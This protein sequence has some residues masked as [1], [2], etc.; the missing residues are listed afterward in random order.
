MSIESASHNS[1]SVIDSINCP[2]CGYVQEQRPDCIKCGVVFSKYYALFPAGKP[3]DSAHVESQGAR[4]SSAD[5]QA[6]LSELQMQ[7]K[8]LSGRFAEIEFEKVERNKLRQ[9]LKNLER[10]LSEN[11]ES[12]GNR[13]EQPPA[14]EAPHET[15]DPR[16]PEIRERLE[17]AESKLGSVDFAG[18][19][20]VE[21]SEK[22]EA[23][24]REIAELSEKN[25]SN[26][27]EIDDLKQQ[28]S[29]LRE[30][31]NRIS[32]QLDAIAQTQKTE[33]P[34]TPL[35]EDVHIIRKNLDELRAFLHKPNES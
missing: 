15:L 30:D 20:M 9:D 29:G 31:F 18:Q 2:K 3:A 14:P 1:G 25:A 17:Q 13:L 19:Y 28:L 33:E 8:T 22:N 35:E 23:N 4:E 26:L 32:T 34:R 5:I 16:L 24:L 12:I 7:I 10:Q 11:L 27:R 6:K 21:L